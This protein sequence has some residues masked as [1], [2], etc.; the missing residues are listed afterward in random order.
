[1]SLF[2]NKPKLSRKRKTAKQKIDALAEK[3]LLESIKKDPSVLRA[4]ISKV[5]GIDIPPESERRINELKEQIQLRAFDMA[6]DDLAHDPRVREEM[7]DKCIAD[8]LG[9][10]YQR[11]RA[12]E[13]G[14]PPQRNTFQSQMEKIMQTIK[15]ADEY[16]KLL[17]V[18][19]NS[20]SALLKDP[21]L[22][23]AVLGLF[24]SLIGPS[25]SP[26]ASSI[27]S[28][29]EQLH[30]VEINGEVKEMDQHSYMEYLSQKGLGLTKTNQ[31]VPIQ[32]ALP[33]A[34]GPA[35]SSANS[36]SS[37]PVPP[38]Q[39]S[40]PQEKA[41][42]S[43]VT[44]PDAFLPFASKESWNSLERILGAMD[45]PPEEF[46]KKTVE[47]VKSGDQ[48]A[49]QIRDFLL[50]NSYDRILKDLSQYPDYIKRLLENR[51]WYDEA[52]AGIKSQSKG[53]DETGVG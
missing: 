6:A 42:Q 51:A 7:R 13:K 48:A 25:G 10:P 2:K 17:G 52:V 23:K 15:Q 27:V 45:K 21:E 8:L 53:T 33:G 3:Y 20:W 36:P 35:G 43:S 30:L 14:G 31:I 39:G 24:Q 5:Y 37:P 9:Q 44:R 47:L 46:V 49:V 29:G 40:K 18:N 26:S 41:T 11:Q 28:S 22:I 19:E 12:R 16:R 32:G 1:M 4:Y 38:K 34:P 50:A